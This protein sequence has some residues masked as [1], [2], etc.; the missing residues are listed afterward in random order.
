MAQAKAPC[1]QPMT[2]IFDLMQRGNASRATSESVIRI[3]ISA[4]TECRLSRQLRTIRQ[5]R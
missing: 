4:S 1:R 2:K 5:P 3:G